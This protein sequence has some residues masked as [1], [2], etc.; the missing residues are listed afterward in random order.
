[1]YKSHDIQITNLALVRHLRVEVRRGDAPS[2]PIIILDN[3]P[4]VIIMPNIKILLQT[5]ER[6][7]KHPR[8]KSYIGI[9]TRN[10]N[11]IKKNSSK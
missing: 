7:R 6:P 2:N 11:K 4:S 9:I 1:L 3:I 10:L 8:P 5:P